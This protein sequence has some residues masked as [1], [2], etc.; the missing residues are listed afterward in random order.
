MLANQTAGFAK[1][2]SYEPL[3]FE[4]GTKWHYS[5][6]GPNW[7]AECL[8]YVYKRD[9]ND[10]MFERVFTPLGITPKD[11]RWR[12]HAYRPEFIEGLEGAKRREFGS[13]FNA[14]VQAMARFGT[15]Y[16]H[17]GKWRDQQILPANFVKTASTVGPELK[18]LVVNDPEL[19]GDASAH[20]GLLWWNNNDGKLE[21]VPRDTYWSWGLYEG[22]TIVIPS[23]DMVVARAGKSWKRTAGADHYAVLE[24]FME[25]IATAVT[26]APK[27]AAKSPYPGSNVIKKVQWAPAST[28]VRKAKGGDN[29]PLTW[30]DDG[31]LYTAYGD[32]RGFEPF[33]PKK[34]SMGLARVEG[35]PEDFHGINLV[36]ENADA[37]GDGPKG[38]KASGMLMV[39]G[40]LYMLARNA[41]NSQLAWSTD[42]GARWAWADWKFTESF[43]CPAFVNFGQNYANAR[44]EFVY[45]VSTDANTAYERSDRLVL[46]RVPKQRIKEQSAFEFFVKSDAGGHSTWSKDIAQR[47]AIF[48][49]P[50]ACYRSHMTYNSA[51]KRYLF[52]TIG[53]GKD[54]RFAGGFGIYDAPEPWGPWTTVYYT[55]HWDTGPGESCSF[56]SNWFSA[57]GTTAALVFSGDDCFSVR[58]VTFV[59]RK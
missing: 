36:S 49:N 28:I 24:P 15:L 53:E 7:L 35:G 40:I 26:D 8:T 47:G 48:T 50:G 38:R 51:L 22:L 9:L 5:D 11:I 17:E 13:G 2:G 32:A 55:N 14:N 57:D 34:L 23:L 6:G 10:V 42:H 25:P 41:G 33:L 29:W 39:N 16:L 21:N 58:K 44:D 1:K 27:S 31:N 59:L 30:A 56:P 3:L 45:I 43:G 37:V 52:T 20:Y 19:H 46:A 18:G 12:K 54:T 4:P